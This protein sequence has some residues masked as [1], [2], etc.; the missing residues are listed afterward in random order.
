MAEPMIKGGVMREFL[1]WY[2]ASEPV[3]GA[4]RVRALA[5]RLP[6]DLRGY[7]D[8][9]EP[10]L[11]LLASSWYPVRVAHSILDGVTEGF[12]EEDV[13]RLAHDSNR[14]I[15]RR[16][17]SSI[18]R[19]ALRRLV[20]PSAYALSVPR[21]W[22]QF[23]NTGDREVIVGPGTTAISKVSRWG[24]HHPALCTITIETMCG[25]FETMGCKDVVWKRTACVSKGAT[26]CVTE[27]EWR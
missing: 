23:H 15:I 24:G 12:T 18:Y 16:G 22:R 25:I 14:W 20:T 7:V 13:R 4:Q 3:A 8:P 17:M 11:K 27:L 5:R 21:L 26:E 19:L 1:E 2:E 10:A 9:D 6:E